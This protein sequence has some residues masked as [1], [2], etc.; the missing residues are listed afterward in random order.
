MSLQRHPLTVKPALRRYTWVGNRIDPDVMAKMYHIRKT[1]GKPI[2]V[3]VAEAVR[4]YAER[5]L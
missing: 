1:T 5:I 4:T 3:Q 2:T